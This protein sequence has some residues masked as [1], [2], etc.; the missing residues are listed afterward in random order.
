MLKAI[1]MARSGSMRVKNKN[2]RPFADS[3]LLTIKIE[4]LKQVKRLDGIIVNSN[5]DKILDIAKMCDVETVKRDEYYASNSVSINEVYVNQAENCDSDYIMHCTCTNPLLEVNTINDMI[6]F[7]FEH[8][9]E[10]KSV[11]SAHQIKEFMWLDGK[12]INYQVEKMP[13]SQ[14]LPDILGLN[15]AVNVL[16]KA[17]LI[18]NRNVISKKPYLY[19]ISDI[20]AIDVD[21]EVDF[22]FAEFMYKKYRMNNN[23]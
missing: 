16:S 3:N 4:Q 9:K 21:W 23:D 19:K 5:D 7:F 17:A 6:D 22:E 1:I 20:E 11:N 15:F 12:P 10:Y 8:E 18:E 13:R 14:D 2:I